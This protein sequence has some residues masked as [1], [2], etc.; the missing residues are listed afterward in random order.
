MLGLA[1]LGEDHAA[2]EYRKA[3]DSDDLQGPLRTIIERQAIEA[4]GAHGEVRTLSNAANRLAFAAPVA[5][6]RAANERRPETL[7]MLSANFFKT[8][9]PA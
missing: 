6:I 2:G 9:P 5:D 7:A 8:F 4:E 1:E 3:L